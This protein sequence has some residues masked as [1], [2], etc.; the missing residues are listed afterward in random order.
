MLFLIF[1]FNRILAVRTLIDTETESP[2]LE[3]ANADKN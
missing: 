1:L 3:K 2:Q